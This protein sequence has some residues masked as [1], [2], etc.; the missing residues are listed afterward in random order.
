M[1]NQTNFNESSVRR[2]I[3]EFLE[4]TQEP[5]TADWK[6]LIAAH[7][8]AAGDIADAA[9]LRR[10]VRHLDE[11]ALDTPLNQAAFDATVSQAINLLYQTPSAQLVDVQT[12]VAAVRGP[13]VRKL[14]QEIGLGGYP[15]LLSGVLAGSIAAPNRIL[16]SLAARF[17]SS[18]AALVECFRRTFAA[19]TIPSYKAEDGKPGVIAKATA[20][21]EAVKSLNL[22]EEETTQLLNLDT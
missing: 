5:T 1:T 19:T 17:D 22:A 12:R 16:D 13:A 4:S 21:A 7:P 15:S 2:I 14:A 3:A 9:L 11:S 18:V 20:W 6:Q 10:G 8:E